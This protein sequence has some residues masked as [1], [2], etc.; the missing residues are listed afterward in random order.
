MIAFLRSA[1]RRLTG[2]RGRRSLLLL[3]V[4]GLWAG[5]YWLPARPRVEW[6]APS[7]GYIAPAIATGA[8]WVATEPGGDGRGP[9]AVWDVATARLSQRL[10]AGEEGPAALLAAP[11]GRLLA[12]EDRRGRLTVWDPLVGRSLAKLDTSPPGELWWAVARRNVGFSPD[13]RWLAY[14]R[15]DGAAVEVW[16]TVAG[17]HHATLAGACRPF[18]FARDGRTLAT[19]AVATMLTIWDVDTGRARVRLEDPQVRVAGLGFA[20]DGKR[21]AIWAGWRTYQGPGSPP[22]GWQLLDASTG[23]AIARVSHAVRTIFDYTPEFSRDGRLLVLRGDRGRELLWDVTTSPPLCLD[24]Q[25]A[26]PTLPDPSGTPVVLTNRLPLFPPSGH[27]L[28]VLGRKSNTLELLD[29]HTL[30]PRVTY[31]TG[32]CYWATFSPDGKTLEAH[33]VGEEA[34]YGPGL[35]DLWS[36]VLTRTPGR[37]HWSTI[38]LFEVSTGGWLGRRGRTSGC[39]WESAFTADGRSLLSTEWLPGDSHALVFRLWDVTP[40]GS[41]SWLIALTALA[42]VLVVAGWQRGRRHKDRRLQAA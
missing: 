15:P 32:E 2:P 29:G 16:D 31:D 11:D 8:A 6:T 30:R 36:Q 7:A 28:L 10:P 3:L 39:F 19:A 14:E 26:L 27:G 5:W 37:S 20:P 9:V 1:L 34:R 41:P 12:I 4:A 40:S 13:G 22:W 18:T 23:A 35:R 33:V 38:E 42:L 17:R 25:V 21:L 24:S